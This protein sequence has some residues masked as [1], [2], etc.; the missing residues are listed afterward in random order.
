MAKDYSKLSKE[1]LIEKIKEL[2]KAKKYGLVW[3]KKT[4]D[5]VKQCQKEL[6]VLVEAK[7]KEIITNKDKPTNF[8]R[9][10]RK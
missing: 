3:E 5:V 6:P 8:E 9:T 7:D 2:E 1:D 10:G 4:E